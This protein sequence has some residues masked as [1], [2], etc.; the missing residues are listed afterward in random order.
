VHTRKTSSRLVAVRVKDDL[1]NEL[2][3]Y[4]EKKGYTNLSKCLRDI[5]YSVVK[6][7]Q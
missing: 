4:C 2:K 5:F 6:S 7:R 1:Y 3:E